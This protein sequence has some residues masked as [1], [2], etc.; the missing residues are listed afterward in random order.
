MM[1]NFSSVRFYGFYCA[2]PWPR[3]PCLC[4]LMRKLVIFWP[5]PASFNFFPSNVE[6]SASTAGSAGFK[7]VLEELPPGAPPYQMAMSLANLR[8][9]FFFPGR[10]PGKTRV[11]LANT[12]FL[13]AACAGGA[14]DTR[15]HCRDWADESSW[16]A[17]CSLWGRKFVAELRRLAGKPAIC[18]GTPPPTDLRSFCLSLQEIENGSSCK[19]QVEGPTLAF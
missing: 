16:P 18:L 11:E 1:Q 3:S 2:A 7:I 13:R 5:V 10:V 17:G 12:D 14:S 9:V 15:R 19:L 8:F 6:S 4:C